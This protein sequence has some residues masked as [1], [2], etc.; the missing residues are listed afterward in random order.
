MVKLL[1]DFIENLKVGGSNPLLGNT[2]PMD[3]FSLHFAVAWYIA[4]LFMTKRWL[5][6]IR[7]T[8]NLRMPKF[9][10]FDIFHRTLKIPGENPACYL[11]PKNLKS[12]GQPWCKILNVPSEPLRPP[13]H[14][15]RVSVLAP[16]VFLSASC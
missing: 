7:R 15:Q 10:L 14:P 12:W 1:A 11:P 16:A 3:A 6:L 4:I 13:Y 9:L 2:S 8:K 5:A